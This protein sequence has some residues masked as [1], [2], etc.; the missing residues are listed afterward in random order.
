MTDPLDT[1]Y[2]YGFDDG[3]LSGEYV[4]PYDKEAETDAWLSYREG[5][6]AGLARFWAEESTPLSEQIALADG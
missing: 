5:Y 6:D 3:H 4:N 2:A 1:A